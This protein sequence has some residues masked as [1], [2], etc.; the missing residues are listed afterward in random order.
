MANKKQITDINVD[1]NKLNAYGAIEEGLIIE[2]P[3]EP[4]TD[5]AIE[6]LK[7]LVAS[8]E[9]LIK[10]A[11]KAEH[12]PILISEE[13]ISFPWF[14]YTEDLTAINAYMHFITAICEMAKTLT[15]VDNSVL[16]IENEKASFHT[17]LLQLG[18]IGTKYKEQR[19][20]LLENLMGDSVYEKTGKYN[21]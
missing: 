19:E 3:R 4:Y 18:F 8:K 6:N 20:I 10:K 7:R 12:L 2:M 16:P 15:I 14:R 13:T 1:K 21:D 11:I 5:T 17:F 9:V